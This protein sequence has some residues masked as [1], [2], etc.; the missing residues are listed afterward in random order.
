MLLLK[1]IRAPRLRNQRVFKPRFWLAILFQRVP[2]QEP[3]DLPY[4]IF[5]IP[6]PQRISLFCHQGQTLGAA[7][8]ADRDSLLVAQ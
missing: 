2:V 1:P 8:A 4:S 5:P 6:N 7:L 3:R